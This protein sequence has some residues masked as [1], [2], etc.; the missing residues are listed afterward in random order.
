M[1]LR[2]DVTLQD[3]SNLAFAMLATARPEDEVSFLPGLD[4]M[5]KGPIT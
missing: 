2:C 5:Y 1:R 4:V 3:L